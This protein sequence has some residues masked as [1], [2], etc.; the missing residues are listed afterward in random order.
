MARRWAITGAARGLGLALVRDLSRRGEQ[1]LALA[2]DPARGAAL[3]G[4][5][6]QTL[7]LAD[8]ASIATLPDRLAAQGDSAPVDV[9]VHNAAIRG[10]TG[11]LASFSAADLAQ[12]MAVNVAAPLLLTRALLPRVPAQGTI[13]FISSRAGSCSEGADPDGDY[14]YCLSKAALNRALCKLD[15]DLPQRCLGL[16]PGWITTDMGGAEAEEDPIAAAARLI[17]LLE[18]PPASGR[19]FDSFAR[20]IGW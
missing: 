14:A 11:G 18:A 13:A 3:P 20:P 9:L 2:R 8:P 7:D 4:V 12:V 17:D 5:I 1:V 10:D 19:F 15:D 16:H 6:W